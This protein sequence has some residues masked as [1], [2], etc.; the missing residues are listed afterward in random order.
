MLWQHKRVEVFFIF[1]ILV[2]FLICEFVSV[3]Y[4]QQQQQLYNDQRTIL[5]HWN[6]W[7]DH[8][9]FE[10]W[11]KYIILRQ[12]LLIIRWRRIIISP[13]IEW[14]RNW[15]RK[16]DKKRSIKQKLLINSWILYCWQY[17]YKHDFIIEWISTAYRKCDADYVS[18]CRIGTAH[19]A[20]PYTPQYSVYAIFFCLEKSLINN[21]TILWGLCACVYFEATRSF[22]DVTWAV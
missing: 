4:Q 21:V 3:V 16:K 1:R 22:D 6:G 7:K 8:R 20:L 17:K 12:N 5:H 11:E 18:C 10:R 2:C 19:W 13:L 9:S 14:K 15:R